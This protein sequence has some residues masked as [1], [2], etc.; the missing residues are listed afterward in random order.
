MLHALSFNPEF[1]IQMDADFSHNPQYLGDMF[2]AAAE[3][4]VVVGSRYVGNCVSVVNWPLPRLF[5]SV[6]ANFYVRTITRV[7]V[8][9]TTGGYRC[10][11]AEALKMIDLPSIHSDGYSFQVETLYRAHRLGLRITE[12]PIIFV[13]RRAGASKMS[14]GVILESALMPWRLR[15]SSMFGGRKKVAGAPEHVKSRG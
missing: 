10:W 15:L 11:R 12:V 4:D 3:H 6:F 8:H 13:E 7:R 14:Q 1:V 5:L 2:A 9:D